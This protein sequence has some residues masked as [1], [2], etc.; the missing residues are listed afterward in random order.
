[1]L[2][3]GLIFLSVCMTVAAQLLLKVGMARIGHFDFH[4]E[5]IIPIG[6]EVATSLP[7]IAGLFFYVIAVIIWMMVLSRAD[8]S[9]AYPLS[10]LGYVFATILAVALFHEHVTWLRGIGVGMIIFGVFM[11][12]QTA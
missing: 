11:I 2:L 12:S 10:S 7:I 3:F 1:M 6:W 9:L 8:V 5:N 4:V